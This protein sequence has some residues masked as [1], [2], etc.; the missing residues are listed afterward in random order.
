VFLKASAIYR[1]LPEMH[2]SLQKLQR[3]LDALNPNHPQ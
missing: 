3:A 2:K 1:R